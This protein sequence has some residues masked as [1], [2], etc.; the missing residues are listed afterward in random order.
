MC[1]VCA[2]ERKSKKKYFQFWHILKLA[3]MILLISGRNN[4]AFAC[5]I[6]KNH[7]FWK[8]MLSL[9]FIN[10]PQNHCQFHQSRTKILH[11]LENICK[12]I[13]YYGYL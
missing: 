2:L 11:I 3:P 12:E 13:M 1:M 10:S 5:L 4:H 8:Y 7:P 6:T 9:D